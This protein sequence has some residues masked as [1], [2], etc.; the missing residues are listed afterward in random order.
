MSDDRE[1]DL[2]AIRVIFIHEIP[3]TSIFEK[4]LGIEYLKES[5]LCI[6]YW[7][8]ADLYLP[9]AVNQWIDPPKLGKVTRIRSLLGLKKQVS[10]LHPSDIVVILCGIFTYQ[11]HSHRDLIRLLSKSPAKLTAITQGNIPNFKYTFRR[12]D[13]SR[14]MARS[15]RILRRVLRPGGRISVRGRL[16]RHLDGFR[17]LEQVWAGVTIKNIDSSL[18]DSNTSVH[19]IHN[20]DF[21]DNLDLHGT[22]IDPH[23]NRAVLIDHMGFSQPDGIIFDVDFHG[24]SEEK[25]FRAVNR[26]LCDFEDETGMTV[27]IA[28]HPRAQP[29]SLES[30]YAGREVFYNM[31]PKLVARSVAVLLMNV[32]TAVVYAVALHK[33][34][35][36]LSSTAFQPEVTHDTSQLAAMLNVPVIDIDGH[37][38][39]WKVSEPDSYAYQRYVEE[40]LKRPDTPHEKFGRVVVKTIV[41]HLS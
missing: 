15:R 24:L 35:I 32:S 2:S 6:E 17:A 11:V 7:E 31:T 20:F 29:G 5:G 34:I 13:L 8:V 12:R 3:F 25:Y 22:E 40:Y 39:D 1:Y 19:F 14:W 38:I 33:S 26:A 16:F 4:R 10:E 30:R 37:P 23:L 36:V 28:A 41:N 18:L 9:A 21:D 27:D